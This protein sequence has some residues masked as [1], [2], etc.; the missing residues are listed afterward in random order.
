[1]TGEKLK[2]LEHEL[3]ELKQWLNLGLVPKKEIEKH[4]MEIDVL[5][6]RVQEEKR[7]LQSLKEGDDAEEFSVPKRNLQSKQPYSETNTMPGVAISGGGSSV[8]DVGIEAE[9]DTA[10]EDKTTTISGDDSSTEEMLTVAED[11]EDPFSDKNRWRRGI[12]EDPDGNSW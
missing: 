11:D 6:K 10:F 1:M 3:C 12:L 5:K 4:K 7:R 8:T 9:S 2:K